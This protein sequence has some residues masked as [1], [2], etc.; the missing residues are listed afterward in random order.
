MPPTDILMTPLSLSLSLFLV[1]SCARTCTHT[2]THLLSLFCLTINFMFLNLA[3]PK[4]ADSE[5]KK[6]LKNFSSKICNA[7]LDLDGL[8]AWPDHIK[9]ILTWI[10]SKVIVKPMTTFQLISVLKMSVNLLSKFANCIGSWARAYK[11]LFVY[12]CAWLILKQSD[13]F[14]K[15]LVNL[16]HKLCCSLQRTKTNQKA[17]IF[18]KFVLVE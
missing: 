17:A 2:C 3:K 13:W 16:L 4:K 12:I 1:D 9:T 10:Y 6:N 11:E 5:Q 15:T 8:E 18:S 7:K 14:I